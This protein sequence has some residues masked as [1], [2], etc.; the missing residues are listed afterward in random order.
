[1][2]GVEKSGLASIIQGF[3]G[4]V[5]CV[6]TLIFVYVVG[7]LTFSWLEREAELEHY[8]RNRFFYKQMRDLYSFDH[9]K[10]AWFKDMEFCKNQGAF[11]DMLRDF[12]DRNGNE[13]EDREKWTFFGSVFFVNTLVT[14]LGY[15][16]FHPR[17]PGGQFFT[18]VFGLVGI[19]ATG[20]VLSFIA[21]VI[22]EVWMPMCS[23]IKARSRR[24]I[25]LCCLMCLFILVGGVLFVAL[26]GWT[27]LNACYFSACTLMTVGFGDFLPS[28]VGSRLV[29]MVFIMLGLGV[30]AS[31][32]AVLTMQ[33]EARGE[34]I[35]ASL[36]AWYDSCTGAPRS[37]EGGREEARQARLA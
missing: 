35:A 22:V 11:H 3:S 30:A 36:G 27:F 15:G 17:T 37:S 33:V 14:T 19:P 9:C 21:S 28:H 12:F 7:G 31:F 4:L 13:M 23:S 5:W 6:G 32:I 25:V 16:N 2:G 29:T 24:I 18:V 34:S 20:Y 26:E 8:A 1:M 10:D